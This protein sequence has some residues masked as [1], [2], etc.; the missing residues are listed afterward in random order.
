MTTQT[1]QEETTFE[2]TET[3]MQNL[4]RNA[5]MVA[6]QEMGEKGDHWPVIKQTITDVMMD[7]ENLRIER[8][9]HAEMKRHLYQQLAAMEQILLTCSADEQKTVAPRLAELREIYDAFF[10][11]VEKEELYLADID[12][13]DLYGEEGK[14]LHLRRAEAIIQTLEEDDE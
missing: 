5:L 14:P 3:Q 10:T 12:E 7:W 9:V 13:E 6:G 2:L 4:V 8:E 1:N 11:D